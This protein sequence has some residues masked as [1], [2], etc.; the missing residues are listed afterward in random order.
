MSQGWSDIS[1]SI[2]S[3]MLANLL[4][5][6]GITPKGAGN[7]KNGIRFDVDFEREYSSRCEYMAQDISSV[8][9]LI[10]YYITCVLA[11]ENGKEFK[12]LEDDYIRNKDAINQSVECA[13]YNAVVWWDVNPTKEVYS[14]ALEPLVKKLPKGATVFTEP[15]SVSPSYD[16]SFSL[17]GEFDAPNQFAKLLES[18]GWE[19]NRMMEASWVDFEIEKHQELGSAYLR[20]SRFIIISDKTYAEMSQGMHNRLVSDLKKLQEINRCILIGQQEFLAL[21]EYIKPVVDFSA[22]TSIQGKNFLLD[23]IEDRKLGNQ[24]RRDIKAYGGEVKAAYSNKVDFVVYSKR[25]KD[26]DLRQDVKRAACRYEK[27]KSVILLRPDEFFE[28]LSFLAP[29]ENDP[30]ETPSGALVGK[31]CVLANYEGKNKDLANMKKLIVDNGG[32]VRK[33]VSS[34]TDYVICKHMNMQT[35]TEWR[36]VNGFR[37]PVIHEREVDNVVEARKLHESGGKVQ[38]ILEEDFL[39]RFNLS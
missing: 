10:L 4:R 27:D 30:V 17:L 3:D 24:I 15:K 18:R 12:E 28:M 32:V 13:Y 16:N 20:C 8:G 37:T 9:N 29:P 36:L 11:V 31:T 39:T 38:L 33:S 19:Y 21:G 35:W 1:I 2:K 7:I 6:H 14:F 22:I 5:D 23:G 25:T 26:V 34:K